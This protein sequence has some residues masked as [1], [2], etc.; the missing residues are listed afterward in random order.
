VDWW[1]QNLTE[2][3][4]DDYHEPSDSGIT[5]LDENKDWRNIV[6]DLVSQRRLCVEV[7]C[8]NWVACSNYDWAVLFQMRLSH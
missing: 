6:W 5:L 7:E 1:Q 8:I 3:P 2:V 4:P